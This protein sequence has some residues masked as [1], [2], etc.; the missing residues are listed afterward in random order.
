METTRDGGVR[1]ED[2]TKHQPIVRTVIAALVGSALEWYDFGLYGAS[3]ALVF[4]HLFFPE[5]SPLAGTLAAFA[6]YAIG[7]LAR[8]IGGI[9]FSHYGDKVGRKPVLAA[10]LLLMGSATC[11]MGLVPTYESIGIWGPLLLV[12]LR[13][14][15]GLGAGAEYGGAALLLAEQRPESRAYYGSFAASGVFIGLVLSVGVFSV[16]ESSL[17]KEEMLSW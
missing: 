10:T 17:S 3:A 5:F 7:F 14:L 4:G 8:P 6:T 9:I 16:V 1:R 13:L 2:E 15:Q 11:L 12:L